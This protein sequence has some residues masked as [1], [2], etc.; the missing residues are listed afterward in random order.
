MSTNKSSKSINNKNLNK[1]DDNKTL[2]EDNK[3]NIYS[4]VQERLEPIKLIYKYNNNNHKNQYIMYIFVG[5]IGKRYENILKKIEKL[6][7]HD[8]L[9]IL[10]LNEEKKLIE[11]FGELWMTKFFNIYHISSFINKLENNPKIK[12]D[13]LKKY[14]E[15]WIV[16]FINKFKNNVIFKKINYSYSDLIKLEYKNMMGKKLD[17]IILTND[18]I[19]FDQK[20]ITSNTS[21]KNILYQIPNIKNKTGGS[22]EIQYGGDDD[23]ISDNDI[24]FEEEQEDEI[25]FDPDSLISSDVIEESDIEKEIVEDEL[26][27]YEDMIKIYQTEEIDKNANNTSTLISNILNDNKIIEKKKTYMVKFD[28]SHDNDIDNDDLSN[29]YEKIF[30]YNHYLF[31]DDTIKTIKDKICITLKNNKKFSDNSYLLP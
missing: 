8:T 16:N 3:G 6:N 19:V 28:D 30:I 4:N 26:S 15:K 11:I 14:D 29:I 22:Y 18:D 5:K 13:L 9:L 20:N 21:S 23:N 10:S 25:N 1:N 2:I 17:K 24:E 12:K 31:K 7:L 27:D